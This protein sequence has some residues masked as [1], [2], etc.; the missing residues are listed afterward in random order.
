MHR[1]GNRITAVCLHQNRRC[2]VTAL[3]KLDSLDQHFECIQTHYDAFKF[4]RSLALE[5]GFQ[6]FLI[7]TL[8]ELDEKLSEQTLLTNWDAEL[9]Q[10]YD[11]GF[12][13]QRGPIWPAFH[14]SALPASISLSEGIPHRLQASDPEFQVLETFGIRSVTWVPLRFASRRPMIVCLGSQSPDKLTGQQMAA[15]LYPLVQLGEQLEQ[16]KERTHR[17]HVI[18]SERETEC[19][20]WTAHG[21]TSVE[22]AAILE[23]SEHTVNHYLAGA[24]RK[25]NA[26]SRPHAVANAL[27]HGLIS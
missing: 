9:L 8:P 7:A 1:F 25:L 2:D 20:R 12:F 19:L 23:L 14:T 26:V 24:G 4:M 13:T 11:E 17:Q 5:F 22:I 16:I 3:K 21:K 27:R 10:I 18:L 6:S 15:L